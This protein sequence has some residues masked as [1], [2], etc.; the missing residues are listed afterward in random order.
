MSTYPL[1]DP[2]IALARMRLGER[3]TFSGHPVIG[4]GTRLRVKPG[5]LELH[6]HTGT[7]HG[8]AKRHQG[9]YRRTSF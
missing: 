7:L 3:R 1:G 5:A 2:P 8:Q 4:C 6:Q 9:A